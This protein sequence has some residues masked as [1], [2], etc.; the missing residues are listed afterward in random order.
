MTTNKNFDDGFEK[1]PSNWMN[2]GKIGNVI[3]GTLIGSY[4]KKDNIKGGMQR[5]YEIKVIDGE[6]NAIVNKIP[7]EKATV[8]EKGDIYQVGGKSM[9]DKQMRNVKIGQKV[10][11]RYISDFKME[12]G[13]VAKTVEIKIGGM[14]EEFL[15]ESQNE[16]VN[17]EEDPSFQ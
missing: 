2:W 8:L 11:M 5:I 15:K 12:Q 14:D 13:N 9:I 17:V 4:D 7:Q 1:A 3:K 16:L 10:L 6:F